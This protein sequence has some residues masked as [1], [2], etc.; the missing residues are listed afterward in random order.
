MCDTVRD[1]MSN[2]SAALLTQSLDQAEEALSS[3]DGLEETRQR[4]EDRSMKLLALENPVASDLRQVVSSIYIVEDFQRMGALAMHI[5]N[6]ARMRHPA[7]VVPDSMRAFVAELARLADDLGTKTHELLVNPD[8]EVALGLRADDDDVDAMKNYILNV[9][10]HHEWEH[11]AREAVDLALL[12][13]YYERYSD[14][15]VNVAA[16]TVFLITGLKPDAYLEKQ[17]AGDGFEMDE[18]FAAIERRFRL[19]RS[20]RPKL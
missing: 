1:V 6:T 3:V 13:R 8:A 5:A 7:P 18:K 16:R 2:A 14:H 15:C 4:C 19:N 12:C 9:L 20:Q 10:T 11:S 17:R